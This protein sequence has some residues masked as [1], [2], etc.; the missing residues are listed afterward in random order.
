MWYYIYI[1]PVTKNHQSR[2]FYMYTIEIHEI[3]GVLPANLEGNLYTI[4]NYEE[5]ADFIANKFGNNAHD[6]ALFERNLLRAARH[7][8]ANCETQMWE[9]ASVEGSYGNTFFMYPAINK[10]YKLSY[11][12]EDEVRASVVDNKLFGLIAT[13]V[14]FNEGSRAQSEYAYMLNDHFASLH[15]NIMDSYLKCADVDSQPVAALDG[16]QKEQF[17]DML[18]VIKAYT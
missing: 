10:D 14:C 11:C 16:K 1:Q 9:M 12:S 3:A 15:G 5:R 18:E 7:L 6:A 8:D 17:K 13:L 4:V 2:D